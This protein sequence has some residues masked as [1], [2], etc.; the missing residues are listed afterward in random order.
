MFGGHQD[1]HPSEAY[2]LKPNTGD[3]DCG[4][5]GPVPGGASD[6][7][8]CRG[9]NC[10]QKDRKDRDHDAHQGGDNGRDRA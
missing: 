10:P 3:Q 7:D 6:G 2:G 9:G 8:G 5:W 4:V 1:K